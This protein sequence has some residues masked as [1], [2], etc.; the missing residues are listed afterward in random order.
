LSKDL[1]ETKDLANDY[2]NKVQALSQELSQQLMQWKA[3]MPIEISTGKPVP[4]PSEQ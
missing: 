1:G 4:F 2:P 3:K